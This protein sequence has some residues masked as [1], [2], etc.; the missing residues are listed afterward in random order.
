MFGMPQKCQKVNSKKILLN[1]KISL[2]IVK[3]NKVKKVNKKR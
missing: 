2:I 3:G 1:V